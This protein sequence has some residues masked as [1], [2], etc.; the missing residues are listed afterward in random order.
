M[1]QA[2]GIDVGGVI[3]DKDRNDDSDTSLFGKNYLNALAVPGALEA[4]ARLNAGIFKDRV[5]IV[6][7]CGE[8]IERRTREW[9]HHSEFLLRTGIPEERLRFCRDRN[10]KAPI[11]E[12]LGLTAFVDDKLEVLGYMYKKVP[13]RFLFRPALREMA[14]SWG[15]SANGVQVWMDWPSLADWLDPAGRKDQQAH[16]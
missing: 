12:E 4:V 2:I 8:H 6:S 11:A 14:K 15:S 16:A 13:N 3:I 1:T 9:L 7:K 5:W 10:Q